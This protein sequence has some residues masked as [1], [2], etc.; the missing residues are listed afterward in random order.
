M[1]YLCS[2]KSGGRQQ[3]TDGQRPKKRGHQTQTPT[4]GR[5]YYENKERL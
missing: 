4:S 1:C 3:I 5:Q 2:G